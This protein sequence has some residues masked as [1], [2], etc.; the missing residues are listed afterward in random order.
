MENDV[1]WLRASKGPIGPISWVQELS[2]IQH[3]FGPRRHETYIFRSFF[4]VD[5]MLKESELATPCRGESPQHPKPKQNYKK[6]MGRQ[7][8]K[9]VK[10]PYRKP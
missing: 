6:T 2:K 5:P 10:K 8:S 9:T 7:D 4:D 3:G 1:N